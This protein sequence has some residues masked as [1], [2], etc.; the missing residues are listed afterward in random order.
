MSKVSIGASA[1]THARISA[2]QDLP[3]NFNADNDPNPDI[4]LPGL[5]KSGY[6][7]QTAVGDLIDNPLDAH[8][9]IVSVTLDKHDSGEW[10]LSV[11]DNGIGMPVEVLDE[12]MRLGSRSDH[13]LSSDLGAFG[14]GSTTASLSLG[15]IQHV[16]TRASG[17]PL[18]SAATDL[19][20]TIR[21]RK[22]VKHI[23]EA[24]DKEA[25]IFIHSFSRWKLAV[26]ET[27][28]LVTVAKIDNIGRTHLN[29][30]LEA[31]RRYIGQTYRYFIWAN[32]RF[33]VN[34]ELVNVIDPLERNLDESRTLIDD[35]FE[36]TF[37]DRHPR[38]GEKESIGAILVELPDWGGIEANRARGY[39]QQNQGF[40][41]LR[42]RREIVA[43]TTFGLFARH[44]KLNRFRGE[45]LFPASLDEDLGV[46]FLKSAWDIKPSQS[47]EDKLS[48]LVMPYA[49]Q[50]EKRYKASAKNAEEQVPHDEAAKVIRQRA[51]FL[52]TP[53]G[54]KERREPRSDAPSTDKPKKASP[55][56]TRT[57]KQPRTQTALA[58]KAEFRVVDGD[59][60]APFFD[61]DIENQRIVITYN[62]RHPF[63]ERFILENRDNRSVIAGID[64][65]VYSLAASELMASDESTYEFI[66]KMREDTSFNL[67]QLLST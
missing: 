58:D 55:T 36:Y 40:Y 24:S 12:M 51:P 15:R 52:R 21:Q 62:G 32:R 33:Y 14:L 61:A 57:P 43:G 64:Y 60:Y 4:L 37:P 3:F 10:L 35:A 22:F 67:R 54:I 30:A 28:T 39:N 11:A 49:R 23:S 59:V 56:S 13:D 63:Y 9:S 44:N 65:L 38:A 45:L 6:T 26:P 53:K 31:L 41:V 5:R 66:S 27:G 16:L 20:E 46:S 17:G 2:L 18:L 8:A 42:N 47:L 50:V 19:D 25:E 29:P 7:L 48:Q 34:G 1:P